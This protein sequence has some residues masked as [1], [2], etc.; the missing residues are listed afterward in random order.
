MKKLYEEILKKD[1]NGNVVLEQRNDGFREES[2][3]SNNRLIRRLTR[4]P[5]GVTELEHYV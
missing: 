1:E 4:Y 3:Y 5:N 2:Q